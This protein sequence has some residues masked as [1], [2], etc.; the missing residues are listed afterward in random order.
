MYCHN[1]GKQI[2]DNSKYCKFCG[3]MIQGANHEYLDRNN[4][5]EKESVP[6]G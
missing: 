5:I 4:D 6:H 3:S 1:C 2:Q